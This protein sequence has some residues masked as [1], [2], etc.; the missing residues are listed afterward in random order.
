M[1]NSTVVFEYEGYREVCIMHTANNAVRIIA[2]DESGSIVLY[3]IEAPDTSVHNYACVTLSDAYTVYEQ[4]ITEVYTLIAE[5]KNA[6]AHVASYSERF[7]DARQ[8]ILAADFALIVAQ[9]QQVQ[10]F[11]HYV[12]LENS[13]TSTISAKIV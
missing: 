1:T 10:A 5:M 7:N 11:L 3:R 6:V 13:N 9:E 8:A 4:A 12:A 2:C